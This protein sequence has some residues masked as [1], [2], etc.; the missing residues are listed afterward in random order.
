LV[1]IPPALGLHFVTLDEFLS[2]KN[3]SLISFKNW[4]TAAFLKQVYRLKKKAY[5]MATG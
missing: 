2:S 4:N 3:V 5:R 1:Q